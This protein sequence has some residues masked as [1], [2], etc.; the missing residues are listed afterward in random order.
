MPVALTSRMGELERAVMDELWSVDDDGW[1]TVREV[2]ER[3]AAQPRHRLHHG[4]DGDGPAV[5]R[6]PWSASSGTGGPTATGPP[7]PRGAMTA[8]LMRGALEE[9]AERDR[10]GALVAFVG[11][12]STEERA[13]LREAL[14][15]LESG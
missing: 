2:H 9:F 13:A 1:L 11:E 12:A 8:D 6:S 4:D 5:G 14:A 10:R 3:L 15:A 7:P